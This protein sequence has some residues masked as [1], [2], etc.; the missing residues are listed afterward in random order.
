[1]EVHEKL[2]ELAALVSGARG[3]PL[4]SSV[5]VDR[6]QLLALVADVRRLLPAEVQQAG[7]VLAQ[8]DE[9]LEAARLDATEL[10]EQARSRAEEL[11]DAQ[12]VTKASRERADHIV[13]TA[14]DEAK[15]LRLDADAWVDRKLA[16]FEDELDRL[17]QQAARG[18]DRLKVRDTGAEPAADAGPGPDAAPEASGSS[19]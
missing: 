18:R 3:V 1:M 4:S 16:D 12:A 19:S 7:D 2:G 14:R 15:R 11:V 13:Q 5:V 9:V 17:K 10:V 6:E 8:R